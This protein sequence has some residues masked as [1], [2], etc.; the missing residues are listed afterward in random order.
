MRVFNIKFYK[1]PL[2]KSVVD[3]RSWTDKHALFIFFTLYSIHV[4]CKSQMFQ[5]VLG[6]R[7][8]LAV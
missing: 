8:F 6:T 3:Y 7:K 5:D 4:T 2:P 1:N